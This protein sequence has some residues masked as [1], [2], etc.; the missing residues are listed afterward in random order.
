M[1]NIGAGSALTNKPYRAPV[2]LKANDQDYLSSH[3]GRRFGTIKFPSHS[4]S[5]SQRTPSG[6]RSLNTDRERCVLKGKLPKDLGK[7][8]KNEEK[9]KR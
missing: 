5:S 6:E 7:R 3:S 8:M 1:R 9:E 2:S 4:S